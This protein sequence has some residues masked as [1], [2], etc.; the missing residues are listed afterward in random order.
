M[1][2]NLSTV[3]LLKGALCAAAVGLFL[4]ASPA[5]AQI[6]IELGPPGAYIATTTPV[7][8]GGRANYW[9][10]NR[11]YYRDGSSWRY[12]HRAP[13]YFNGYR[14]RAPARAFYGRGG[15]FG[16]RR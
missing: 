9:Y 4:V 1:T 3:K 5:Q 14:G 2:R 7:Y 12:Y 6:D 10:G 16:R 11:W 8:Y 13:A 15:G